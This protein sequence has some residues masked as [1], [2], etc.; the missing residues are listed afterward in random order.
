VRGG[1]DDHI[2]GALNLQGEEL[3]G[4]EQRLVGH[5]DRV[6]IWPQLAENDVE[7]DGPGA[8]AGQLLG[9]PAINVARPIQSGAKTE[10]SVGADKIDAG[11][12]DGHEAEV[13]GDGKRKL[14]RFARAH[15]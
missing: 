8:L 10:G 12:I 4:I 6:M 2:A 9:E 5:A 11:F 13:T 14:Q 7:G 1:S 15:V 3:I